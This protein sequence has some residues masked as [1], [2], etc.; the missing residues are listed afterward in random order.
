MADAV[1]MPLFLG[2]MVIFVITTIFL[3][4]YGYRNTKSNKQFMLGRN[5]TN[6]LIIALSY[7]ATF[8]SASA[9][10]GFGGQAAVHG[11]TMIWLCFL[12]LF[13]GLFV[14][15]IVFG[16]RVRRMG[17][18]H[19][20]ST[21][22]D[23]FGKIFKSNGIRGFAA[24]IIIIMMPIYCAAV[25]KAGANSLVTFMGLGEFYNIIVIILAIVVGAYVVYGGII[26]VMYNDALQ[27]GIMFAGMVVIFIVTLITVGGFTHATEFL[28]GMFDS[29]ASNAGTL[30]GFMGWN[31]FPAFNSPEFWT[32]VSTFILGVGIGAL[33][34]PQLVVRF[35]SAKDDKTLNKSLIIG[36]IFMIVI[37]ASAYTVGAFTNVYFMET[38]GLTTFQYVTAGTDYIIPTYVLEVFKQYSLGD[39]F[40]CVFILAMLAAAISTLSA[41]MH[42]IGTAGGHDMFAIW[43]D[44][45]KKRI[46]EGKPTSFS[47]NL[48]ATWENLKDGV[49]GSRQK[50]ENDDKQSLFVNRSVTA[51]VMV[52]TVVYCFLMPSDI[53]AKATSLF[54]GLTAAAILPLMVYGLF[55]KNPKKNVALVSISVGTASY[56]FWALFINASSSI[57]LPICKMLTGSKVLFEGTIQYV[58]ALIISLPLSALTLI[59]AYAYYWWKEKKAAE[60]G[61]AIDE[62]NE[63]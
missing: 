54:M 45:K 12:N 55:G 3:G 17:L 40:I 15:F 48:G 35:M 6:P 52:L 23:L 56:L 27:A 21:F 36:S 46:A 53:V 11:M 2:V 49:R 50:N 26:A 19:G 43:R 22:S 58:D 31:S 14:A 10:V 47:D 62:G 7:G 63:S 34:Q 24:A 25:L 29:G 38:Y 16:R 20:A 41:L 13:L 32:V 60:A 9:I 61:I 4:W 59:I 33:T 37:V 1:S 42:T 51:I 44:Y 57:F 39:L 18:K 30:P 5:K 28:T 8:L